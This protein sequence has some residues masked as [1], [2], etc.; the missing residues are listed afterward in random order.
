MEI[1]QSL[2]E[3][4][5]RPEGRQA[6]CVD[7]HQPAQPINVAAGETGGYGATENLPDE[8]RRRGA[9][10]LDQRTQ[11]IQYAIGLNRATGHHRVPVS[12]HVRGDDPVGLG[13]FRKYTDPL[14]RVLARPVQEHDGR[15]VP[16]LKDSG[17]HTSHIER[18]LGERYR[19]SNL[20]RAFSIGRAPLASSTAFCFGAGVIVPSSHTFHD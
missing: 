6:Q 7:K 8:G 12:R 1:G 19:G 5:R 13:Q 15:A 2:P 3:L 10:M 11:P 16:T 20:A 14:G 18:P 17:L 4:R 9:R